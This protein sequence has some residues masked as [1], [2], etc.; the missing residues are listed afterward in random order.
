MRLYDKGEKMIE[1]NMDM[2]KI[3]RSLRNLKIFIKNTV[4]DKATMTK[5]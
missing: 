4:L 3:I 2:V 5:I 1:K